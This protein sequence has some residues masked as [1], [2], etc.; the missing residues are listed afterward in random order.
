MLRNVLRKDLALNAPQLWDLLLWFG[1]VAYVLY[2]APD[3]VRLAAGG[4]A[5]VGALIACT[6]GAREDKLRVSATLASLPVRRRAIVQGRYA[7]A[8]AV[9]AAFLL[10]SRGAPWPR[11]AAA[12]VGLSFAAAYGGFVA[13]NLPC[14][15][16]WGFG[17]GNLAAA[18]VLAL[19]IVLADA[20]GPIVLTGAFGPG[21]GARASGLPAGQI[22]A[23]VGWVAGRLGLVSASVLGFA[24]NVVLLW[25]SSEIAVRAARGREF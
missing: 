4:S 23:G 11:W 24:G 22:P 8:F 21:D 18:L 1:Y 25:L 5:L 6:I 19:G 16:R 17:R 10:E 12:D 9:G 7:V 2:R 20:A 13:V 15:S 3:S 14:H